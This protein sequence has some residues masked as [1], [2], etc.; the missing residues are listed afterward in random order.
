[1]N[2]ILF[3]DNK[4]NS[5]SIDIKKIIKF[6]AISIIIIGLIMVCEGSY[7]A[8]S[9]YKEKKERES[10]PKEQAD[11]QLIQT[12]DNMVNISINSNIGISELLYSWNSDTVNTL[13]QDG[14]TSVFETIDIPVGE[15]TLN[16]KVIDIN[17]IETTTTQTFTIVEEKAVIE[18]SLVGDEIK[19]IVTSK[20]DLSNVTY[21][22]N[23]DNVN[24]IDMLTYEDKK[25]FMKQIQIP[26]GQNT[27]LITATDIKGKTSEKSQEVKGVTKPKIK[28]YAQNGYIHFNVAAEENIEYVEFTFNG[29]NYKIDSSVVGDKKEIHYK[30]ELIEGMNYIKITA[31]TVSGAKENNIGKYNYKKE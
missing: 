4:K 14:K 24:V 27:L 10:I 25:N 2:Q 22:W 5:S 26:K 9:Y 21:K 7:S 16:I 11:I 20:T 1:M 31:N 15:N 19:I 3:V 28:I 30:M 6:F 17:G 18:L 29:Q 23:S 12:E 13:S 8:Y